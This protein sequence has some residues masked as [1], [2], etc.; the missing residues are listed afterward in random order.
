MC[1]VLRSEFPFSAIYLVVFIV[2]HTSGASIFVS[3]GLAAR[4]KVTAQVSYISASS[5]TNIDVYSPRCT[6]QT[7]IL[8]IHTCVRGVGI[9]AMVSASETFQRIYEQGDDCKDLNRM[10]PLAEFRIQPHR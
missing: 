3:G 10:A 7:R 4:G 8:N 2:L 6:L 1:H 5:P 9:P